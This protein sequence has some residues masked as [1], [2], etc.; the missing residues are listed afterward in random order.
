[1][2][3]NFPRWISCRIVVL[4]TLIAIGGISARLCAQETP[5]ETAAAKVPREVTTEQKQSAAELITKFYEDASWIDSVNSLLIRTQRRQIWTEAE[6]TDQKQQPDEDQDSKLVNYL[7]TEENAWD[8]KRIR[9]MTEFP[10][11]HVRA[12]AIRPCSNH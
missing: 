12:R 6:R 9:S 11:Q 1:M 7:I 10:L 4:V 2:M 3:K 5:G 8:V